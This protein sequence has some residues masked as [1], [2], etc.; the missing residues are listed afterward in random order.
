MKIPFFP[1]NRAFKKYHDLFL[2]ELSNIIKN[3]QYIFG[4]SLQKLE[5]RIADYTGA[6]YCIGVGNATDALEMMLE[7]HNFSREDEI[8]LS[9]H[10]M[11]AT[12]SSI[13]R[14]SAKPVPVDIQED[15]LICPKSI[16]ESIN[17][18]TK[19]LM[20]T[21]LN[22]KTCNMDEIKKICNEKNLLLFEDSAQA[23]GSR[24][25]N[26]HAGTFGS[27]GCFSFYP[28]KILGGPG[29]GG[30]LITSNTELYEWFS[31]NRDHGR[32][33]NG[34]ISHLGRNSRLDNL[35]AAFLNIQ[36]DHFDEFIERRRK[37]AKK[38]N[39]IL[40]NIDEIKCPEYNDDKDNE[41]F[42]T[43]QNYEILADNRDQL[44]K[45]LAENEVGTLIQ[46]GGITTNQIENFS[47]NSKSK[48]ITTENYYKRCLMLPMN[49]MITDDEID[50][51]NELIMKFYK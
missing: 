5:R 39:D 21:Q 11:I 42:D 46:W 10:T 33:K 19:A 25:K 17:K 29:D 38:Y 31:K 13:V 24:Y 51:I 50:I 3:G 34:E 22:G 8:I 28:A 4:E 45:Y 1:Y 9:S 40:K 41:H 37:V 20:I 16:L 36:F 6:K 47:K 7:Y 15:G 18:N 49:T 32:S 43:F 2:N 14:S 35:M 30:A 44:K 48:F 23:L 12:L 26:Q 27:A